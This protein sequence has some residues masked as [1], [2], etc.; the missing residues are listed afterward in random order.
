MSCGARM[1][2]TLGANTIVIQAPNCIESCFGA[3]LALKA[4]HTE[5]HGQSVAR[6]VLPVMRLMSTGDSAREMA[7]RNLIAIP[8]DAL[9]GKNLAISRIADVPWIVIELL[10]L[11]ELRITHN[12]RPLGD[13]AFNVGGELLRRVGLRLRAL[14]HQPLAHLGRTHDLDDFSV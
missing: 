14:A 10:L 13:F 5:C 4:R 2:Q 3:R 1:E 8:C 9:P 12:F 6:N 11:R 7:R